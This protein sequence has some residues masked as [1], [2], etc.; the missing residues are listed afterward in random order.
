MSTIGDVGIWIYID[1]FTD[2]SKVRAGTGFS[3]YH[4]GGLESSFRPRVF[5]SEMSAIDLDKDSLSW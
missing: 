3:V 1:I 5:I 4:S 2:G